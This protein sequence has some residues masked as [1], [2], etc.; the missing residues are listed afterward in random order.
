MDCNI[1]N[2][3]SL[4]GLPDKASSSVSRHRLLHSTPKSK[5]HVLSKYTASQSDSEMWDDCGS[6]VEQRLGSYPWSTSAEYVGGQPHYSSQPNLPAAV[7][8]TE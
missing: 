3:H 8:H 5:S 2:D 7:A 1:D 6:S 4:T